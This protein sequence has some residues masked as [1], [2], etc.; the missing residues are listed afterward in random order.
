MI[1]IQLRSQ[2][3]FQFRSLHGLFCLELD[4]RDEGL[5]L[6]DYVIWFGGLFSVSAIRCSLGVFSGN[7]ELDFL[8]RQLIDFTHKT[9]LLSCKMF[10][11]NF[12]SPFKKNK[13]KAPHIFGL[14][15]FKNFLRNVS[16]RKLLSYLGSVISI[17]FSKKQPLILFRSFVLF[18]FSF[19][20]FEVVAVLFCFLDK[21]CMKVFS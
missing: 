7:D 13:Q 5:L 3:H 17:I 9:L 18:F 6:P 4:W 19:F 2:P 21:Y 8:W 11:S 14:L 10:L 16:Q 12:I 20:S 1:T 15:E